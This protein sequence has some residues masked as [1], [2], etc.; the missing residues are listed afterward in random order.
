MNM[1]NIYFTILFIVILILSNTYSQTKSGSGFYSGGH[2][3]LLFDGADK[4]LTNFQKTGENCFMKIIN[5]K[6]DVTG[7]I[8]KREIIDICGEI[9]TLISYEKTKIKS[10][11][12]DLAPGDGIKT[13]KDGLVVL[14]LSDGSIIAMH[15]NTSITLPKDYCKKDFNPIALNNGAIKIVK[16]GDK[17]TDIGTN[18]SKTKNKKTQFS[19]EVVQ[20]G[21]V[22][23][24]ILRVYEGSVTFEQNL[25]NSTYS[26]DIADKSKEQKDKQ[27]QIQKLTEDFQSGK[28]SAQEY[29]KKA[30]EM[31]EEIKEIATQIQ[32]LVPKTI[33]VEAG[34]ESRIV[35]T[36]SNPTDPVPID[37]NEKP[38][39]EDPNLK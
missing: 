4:N 24:D 5:V 12:Y 32:S 20:D 10:D 17:T 23:T 27:D 13:G 6:G 14:E 30:K 3:S 38:W 39:W 36:G 29:T 31:A 1:K 25:A 21:D 26:K 15:N 8:V 37:A 16:T 7:T 19:V 33:T 22:M 34:Y 35:G 11:L 9:D 18:Q 28:I 2:D